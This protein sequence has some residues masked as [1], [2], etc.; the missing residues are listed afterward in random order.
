L[1]IAEVSCEEHNSE[2][3]KSSSKNVKNC[4]ELGKNGEMR[5]DDMKR[6]KK[7]LTKMENKG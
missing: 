2:D 5:K 7:H 1:S 4:E 3:E 6:I